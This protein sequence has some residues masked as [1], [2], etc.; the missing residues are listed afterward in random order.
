ML[1]LSAPKREHHGAFSQGKHPERDQA[2]PSGG[3]ISPVP[4]PGITCPQLE[5]FTHKAT[6]WHPQPGSSA[7]PGHHW[8]PGN[9]G[10]RPAPSPTRA[11]SDLRTS[12]PS[13]SSPSFSPPFSYVTLSPAGFQVHL[14]T[15][16]SNSLLP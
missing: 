6:F 16:A 7:R 5:G 12:S 1:D 10:C 9:A 13:P 11:S 15:L 3:I 2:W 14:P 4:R 8:A